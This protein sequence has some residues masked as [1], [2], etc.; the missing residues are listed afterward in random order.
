MVIQIVK[1]EYGEIVYH[2]EDEGCIQE[3]AT[4]REAREY[5]DYVKSIKIS[6]PDWD[7]LEEL[8]GEYN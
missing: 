3:F 8:F 1:N 7:Q 6:R 2:V 4:K 5:I